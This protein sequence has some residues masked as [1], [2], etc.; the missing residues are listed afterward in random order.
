VR[1]TYSAHLEMSKGPPGDEKAYELMKQAEKK[2][3]KFSLFSSNK[4]EEAAEIYQK[5]ASFFKLAKK[6]NEAGDAFVKSADCFSKQGNKYDAATNYNDAAG[7]YKKISPMDAIRCL[8]TASELYMDLGRFAQAAKVKKEI[9]ETYE[10][11]MNFENALEAF[12]EAANYFQGEDS[13]SSA[14]QCLLKVGQLAAQLDNFDKAIEVYEKVAE[15]SV[16][17]QLLKWSVKDYYLRAGICYLCKGASM[18]LPAHMERYSQMDV[19]FN[20]TREYRFLQDIVAAVDNT[21]VETFTNV[22]A[23]F[24]QI[25]KLDAWKTSMLLKIKQ[26]MRDEDDLL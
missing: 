25:S 26:K 23:D 5:A 4:H 6:Y 21:D 10:A 8:N 14:N 15:A 11:E 20:S 13:L 22:V 17:S 12:E 19:T 3:K 7:C 24:D 1:G 18:D 2:L 9:G 16:E